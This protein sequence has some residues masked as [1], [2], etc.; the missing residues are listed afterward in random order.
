MTLFDWLATPGGAEFSHAVVLLVVS[1]AAYL[2]YLAHRT[3]GKTQDKLDEH[4]RNGKG[5][6]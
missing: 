2:S 4:I 1:A 5:R 6:T 3:A